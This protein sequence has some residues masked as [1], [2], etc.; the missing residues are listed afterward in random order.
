MWWITTSDH[1]GS[2]DARQS[3]SDFLTSTRSGSLLPGQ[4]S[5]QGDVSQPVP[6]RA[7]SAD[8]LVSF[9]CVSF[10]EQHRV[11]STPDEIDLPVDDL[12]GRLQQRKNRGN[13]RTALWEACRPDSQGGIRHSKSLEHVGTLR[14]RMARPKRLNAYK[15]RRSENDAP[16]TAAGARRNFGYVGTTARLPN[17]HARS[18]QLGWRHS[19]GMLINR[20]YQHNQRP[21]CFAGGQMTMFL[22]QQPSKNAGAPLQDPSVAQQVEVSKTEAFLP[23]AMPESL[24]LPGDMTM[25]WDGQATLGEVGDMPKLRKMVR[26]SSGNGR[27]FRF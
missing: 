23:E 16:S 24:M 7:L 1:V 6:R 4:P 12:L 21:R 25:R 2:P 18:Q 13:R 5:T 15:S 14:Q 27:P 17:P 19:R 9:S 20:D 26:L 3:H 10:D 11:A 8:E 22:K